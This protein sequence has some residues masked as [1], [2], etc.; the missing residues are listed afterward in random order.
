MET[1]TSRR[2]RRRGRQ[3]R[4]FRISMIQTSGVV[5]AKATSDSGVRT[6]IGDMAR[7]GGVAG[8]L[9]CLSVEDVVA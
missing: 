5:A 4:G 2:E 7:V 8:E 3:A 9:G 6:G 1:N